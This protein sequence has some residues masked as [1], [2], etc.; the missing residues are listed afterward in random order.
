MS[1]G[2]NIPTREELRRVEGFLCRRKSPSKLHTK[3]ISTS[4]NL[5]PALTLYWC[6]TKPMPSDKKELQPYNLPIAGILP[7]FLEIW[8][9]GVVG[10][11]N[12]NLL[13][14][15]MC[16]LGEKWKTPTLESAKLFFTVLL[17]HV[18]QAQHLPEPRQLHL[19]NWQNWTFETTGR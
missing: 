9:D 1:F 2:A 10:D 13:V 18:V 5:L 6:S 17:G 16:N 14:L 11:F 7:H 4:S 12:L 3:Y 19:Q 8:L 15:K